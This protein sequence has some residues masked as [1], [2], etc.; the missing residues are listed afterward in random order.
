M[1]KPATRDS[2]LIVDGFL[3]VFDHV[4]VYLLHAT[5]FFELS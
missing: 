1:S 4:F 3:E 2:D 5:D